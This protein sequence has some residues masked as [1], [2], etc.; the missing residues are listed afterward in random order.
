MLYPAADFSGSINITG[1]EFF[2]TYFGGGHYVDPATYTISLL[3]TSDASLPPLGSPLIGT[4]GAT[5]IF[6][7]TPG[8]LTADNSLI[9]T[10]TTDFNYDPS[11]GNLLL[12]VT[13]SNLT[14]CFDS[15][16]S[17]GAF[18]ANSSLQYAYTDGTNT[19][20]FGGGLVTDFL[21]NVTTNP[22]PEPASLALMSVGLLGLMRAKRR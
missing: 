2:D 1:L 8:A 11:A 5:T 4:S 10:A 7:G 21:G 16:T 19:Y 3:T 14:T 22:V 6:S 12:D 18:D 20:T 9:I 15:G 13:V 17:C